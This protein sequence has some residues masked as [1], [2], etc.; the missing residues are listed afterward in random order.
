M[1]NGLLNI[2][3]TGLQVSQNQ[4][5]TT[6]NNI[7]NAN[8]PGYSR[9]RVDV[10][11]QDSFLTS[12]GYI[13]TG[14]KAIDIERVVNQFVIE[15]VRVSGSTYSHL[16]EYSN[17]LSHLDNLLAN[18]SSAMSEVLNTF[19]AS[20]A[21]ASDDPASLPARE[22][23]LAQSRILA[24]RFNTLDKT[25]SDI[26]SGINDELE[27]ITQQINILANAIGTLNKQ[28]VESSGSASIQGPNSLFDQRDEL[29]KELSSLVNV[30]VVNEN[31]GSANV[32]FGNGQSLVVGATTYELRTIQGKA[33]PSRADLV[34]QDGATLKTITQDVTGGKMGGLLEYRKNFLD[35]AIN[36]LGRMAITISDTMNRIQAGGLDLEGHY[37]SDLF[38]DINDRESVLSRVAYHV[39]NESPNDRIISVEITDTSK[40][41][42]D[43][44]EM[45]LTGGAPSVFEILDSKGSVVKT[46]GLDGV[47]PQT[48]EMDGF[49]ITLESGN[50]SNGDRFI[51]KPTHN[52]AGNISL[53][54]IQAD[55]LAFAQP[56][57]TGTSS[58]NTGNGSISKGN[59]VS[60]VDPKT[61]E[62][63]PTFQKSGA[64]APPLLIQFTS[65]T[66]Y[67][68]L[69]NTDP[70]NPISLVPPLENLKFTPGISNEILPGNDGQTFMISDGFNAAR[71]P[72]ANEVVSGPIG[73]EAPN[74]IVDEVITISRTLDNG[75]IDN[76]KLV[77]PQGQSA[78][79]AAALLSEAD[80]VSATA[81]SYAE[82]NVQDNGVG[83]DFEF[84]LNGKQLT[85]SQPNLL[86][87]LPSPMTNDYLA[88]AINTD[89][90]LQAQ[91]IRA[92]SDG[93]SVKVYSN[94]GVD[95]KFQVE[96]GTGDSVEFKGKAPASALG[97]VNV[98]NPVNF[99]AGGPNSFSLDLFDGPAGASN[100]RTVELEGSFS[101][102]KLL[103][104]HVQTQ[105]DKA[106]GEAG[107]VTV[108]QNPDGTIRFDTVDNDMATRLRVTGPLGAD[109]LGLAAAVAQ[110]TQRPDDIL[111][112]NGVGAG[113]VQALTFAGQVSVTMEDGYT[114][115]T[116]AASRGNF[117]S[118]S[119]SAQPAFMGYG[120]NISG[121]PDKGDKFTVDF[122]TDGSSDNRNAQALIQLMD[123]QTVG[124]QASFQ[125]AY[126]QI[127]E[128]I[129]TETFEAK[130]NRDAAK[131]VHEQAVSQRNS[132]SAV[133][134]DEEAANLIKFEQIYN[135]S[136]QI[137]NV[138]RQT[139]DTLLG[140]FR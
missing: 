20:V 31:D 18:K 122:N 129:A 75:S 127:V 84:Y 72:M 14:A 89:G 121:N 81:S 113:N 57:V 1:S 55:G 108:A 4:L 11:T 120:L 100:P 6:G 101:D 54:G 60:A 44:F 96:G 15:Q 63:L 40:L 93:K 126:S 114:L 82:F 22:S 125:Q 79:A 138:S 32:F 66:S 105:V 58:G 41:S 83:T 70:S 139:F 62:L 13:G 45:R 43:N 28:I 59:V 132:I 73:T 103:L 12:A 77:I 29:M 88:D 52:G 97:T 16:D 136:S 53:T 110:G 133:N 135:A 76:Q 109:P 5:N 140:I 107:K 35:P 90:N 25:M 7:T 24:E 51:I 102:T 21:T 27:S 78:Q 3:R 134:L 47:F 85:L 46:G 61:G 38:R 128:K 86:G 91:G 130:S 71:T 64:L 26:A 50:F 104:E 23:V 48:I 65:E 98:N 10:A 124:G 8:T 9:Q 74:A 118:Q 30:S 68:V 37:G 87:T 95:L 131:V 42:A 111:Q 117:F 49:K 119:S 39:E 34:I 56:I 80:G 33:D 19:T 116:D 69:D 137:I 99:N 92:V 67:D 123:Q 2:G 17:K 94:Q 36:E 112:V 106:F 115:G